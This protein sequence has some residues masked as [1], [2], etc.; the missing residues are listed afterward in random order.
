VTGGGEAGE[1]YQQKFVKLEN[2]KLAWKLD[3][4]LEKL[5]GNVE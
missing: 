2:V 3:L 4:M 1:V 5:K